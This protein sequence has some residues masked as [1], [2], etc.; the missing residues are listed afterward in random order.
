MIVRYKFSN[1]HSFASETEVSFELGRQPAQSDYDIKLDEGRRLNK[2]VAVVGANGSGKTQ[3]IKPLAFVSW[4]ICHSFL[5][6]KPEDRIP[7]YPHALHKSEDTS[8]EVQFILNDNEYKYR[9]VLN[10]DRVVRESLHKKTS[11]LYSYIFV[12]K[13]EAVKSGKSI[14]S[15]KSQGFSFPKNQAVGVRGNASLLG[16]AF[17]YDVP[18]AGVFVEYASRCVHNLNVLGRRHFDKEALLESGKFFHE[19]SEIQPKME[20]AICDFDLGLN[21][22]KIKE[23]ESIQEDG[24]RETV[25]MPVGVHERDSNSFELSFFEES[26]GTQSAL[27]LLSRVLPVLESGGLAVIDEID[28]DLHPHLLPK[29]IDWFKFKHTN[30]KDAQIIFTCHTPEVLSI[31]RKH[32]VY[33]TEKDGQQSEAWRLD[34]VANLRAD[35]NLYAKYMAGALGAT[36]DV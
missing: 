3:L 4:F 5:G 26:S 20:E 19:F 14:Y 6:S 30:P 2:V 17:N 33:L 35:D 15:F 22:V 11:H 13:L 28:N 10:R 16:A 12:R 27:V 36:P 18:E 34:G 7:F 23:W 29:V 8:F 31:L 24:T 9:L 25:Y 1:F 32:Q 21:S